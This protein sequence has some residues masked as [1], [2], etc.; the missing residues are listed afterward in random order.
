MFLYPKQV[1]SLGLEFIGLDSAR[2]EAMSAEFRHEVFSW[3]YGSPPLVIS[4]IWF[5]L[6][7]GEYAGAYLIEKE[8]TLKGFKMFMISIFFLWVY[9]RNSSLISTR[10][11]VCRNYCNGKMLWK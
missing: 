10:F 9:P 4:T 2:Q 1:E 5:D 11:G 8:N 3:H 6:Q 7:Q